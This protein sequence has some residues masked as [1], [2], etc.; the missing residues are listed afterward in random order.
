[1]IITVII[2]F[3]GMLGFIIFMSAMMGRQLIGL[4]TKL[5]ESMTTIMETGDFHNRVEVSGKDEFAEM[6]EIFN[7]LLENIERALNDTNSVMDAIAKGDF[8]KRIAFNLQGE[9]ARL[10]QGVN[11]SADSIEKTMNTLSNVMEGLGK[12]DL[13]VRMNDDVEEVFRN[14]VNGAMERVDDVIQ[15]VESLVNEAVSGDLSNRIDPSDFEGFMKRIAEAINNLMDSFDGVLLQ[16][17]MV[18]GQVNDS[19]GQVRMSSQDL[20]SSMEEQSSA[21]EEVSTSLEETDSQVRS[22]AQNANVANQL[23]QETSTV[24][25]QGQVKMREMIRSMGDISGSSQEIGKIIKVIDEI[26]FQTN[27]L[28]LNAAVEAARAG[29]YGKG[30]A[31][32]A[33]EVRELAGRSAE[34]AKETAELIEKST[35]QVSDGVKI[36]DAT[37]EALEGIVEN[38]I[39][40]RDLVA[41]ISTAS[42]E[43]TKGITQINTAIS[44]VSEGA[45]SGSQQSMEM[46]NAGDQLSSLTDQLNSEVSR[47]KL[48]EE[49]YVADPVN[50]VRVA[51][52][53][54]PTEGAAATTSA[55]T[56]SRPHEVLSLDQDERDFG[57]F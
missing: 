14:Q 2:V 47:F 7:R 51:R 28:A 45:Q 24:A 3:I 12:G 35:H 22:N 55:S 42:D 6:G 13:S 40:V 8:K 49:E 17:R 46:A 20:A 26:A 37:A 31:V 19:V 10:E 44:Q 34:A 43:Q 36:A 33:Q 16:T 57:D 29:K 30:F 41:E 32:V 4:A 23:V 27:L 48:K 21:I 52:P 54:N 1:M 5:S 50:T 56:G 53:Q 25:D 11:A 39:K 9:F 15:Q 18:I 38:V